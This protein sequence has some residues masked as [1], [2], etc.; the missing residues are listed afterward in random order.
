[1]TRHIIEVTVDATNTRGG[2]LHRPDDDP[3]AVVDGELVPDEDDYADAVAQQDA[4]G[5]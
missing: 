2:T 3:P 1:M 4:E 5:A